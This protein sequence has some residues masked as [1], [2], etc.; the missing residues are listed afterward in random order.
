MKS[1]QNQFANQISQT[2]TYGMIHFELKVWFSF[3]FLFIKY[4]FLFIEL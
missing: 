1:A 2:N 3:F 4:Y